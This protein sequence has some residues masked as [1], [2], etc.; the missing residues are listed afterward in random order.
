[1]STEQPPRDRASTPSSDPS[2]ATGPTGSPVETTKPVVVTTPQS[3]PQPAPQPHVSRTEA[4]GDTV[5]RWARIVRF[6][7]IV[8]LTFLVALFVLRNF[9]D[10]NVDFVFGDINIPLAV[11]ML[12]SVAIGM[13]LGPLLHW[14]LWSRHRPPPRQR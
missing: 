7:L 3:A 1:M 11:V 9:D 4:I 12:I 10:V 2:R 14:L 8:L 6:I 13:V 5:G